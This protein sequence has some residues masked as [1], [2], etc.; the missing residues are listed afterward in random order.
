MCGVGGSHHDFL[1]EPHVAELAEKL[2]E[3]L[4]GL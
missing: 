4:K 3:M 1:I 2:R